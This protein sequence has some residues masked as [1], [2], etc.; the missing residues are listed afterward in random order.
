MPT[1][2]D[3]RLLSYHDV[4]LRKSDV[5]LLRGPHWLNDQVCVAVLGLQCCGALIRAF[6]L[7]TRH[8]AQ[9]IAFYFE[10]LVRELFPSISKAVALI[11]GAMSFLLLNTGACP[12]RV[13]KQ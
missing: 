7:Y 13:D 8:V 5:Q 11:P 2:A 12:S 6:L 9:I 1:D 3:A 4:L 10:Y